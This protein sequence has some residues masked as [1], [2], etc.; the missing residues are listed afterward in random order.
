MEDMCSRL[1]LKEKLGLI[2][3]LS[4]KL[5]MATLNDPRFATVTDFNISAKYE[6]MLTLNLVVKH[7]H[8]LL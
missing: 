6:H 7:R 4:N 5:S 2:K 8:N 1:P 3:D